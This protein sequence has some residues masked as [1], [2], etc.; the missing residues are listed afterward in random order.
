MSERR[1]SPDA[2]ILG[3][4]AEAAVSYV[5]IGWWGLVSPR[6]TERA[7]L[8]LA[9]GIVRDGDRV[10]LA[11]RDDLWGWELPGGT[12]ESGETAEDALVRELREETGVDVEIERHVGDYVRTGF[13][14]HR[15]RVYLC[16][17]TGGQP[18]RGSEVRDVAWFPLDRLPEGLFPW[19]VGPLR[20]AAGQAAPVEHHE[21]QGVA[22]IARA[23]AIDLRQR[24]GG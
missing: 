13:R 8:V 22:V 7:P 15:A 18:S 19:Y 16:R 11:M 9:Q 21:R 14:P 3:R 2:G 17:A 5:R 10:L 1:S 20:D 12:V 6:V 4:L 23:I 24:I